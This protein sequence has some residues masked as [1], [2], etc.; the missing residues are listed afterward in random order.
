M[1]CYIFSSSFCVQ[2]YVLQ[3]D[4]GGRHTPFFTNYRPTLY[5]DTAAVEVKLVLPNGVEMVMPGDNIEVQMELSKPT[6][7]EEAQ[8]FVLREGGRTIGSGVIIQIIV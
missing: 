5:V 1:H 3:K 8:T 2:V 6:L 7:C 4:E